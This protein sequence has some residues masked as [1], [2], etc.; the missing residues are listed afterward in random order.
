M[1]VVIRN[2]PEQST[3]KQVEVFFRDKLEKLGIATFHCHKSKGRMAYLTFADNIKALQFMYNHGQTIDGAKGH[4][5][6][7]MKL[8]FMGR[9]INCLQ[10]KNVPDPWLLKSLQK[11][12]SD[13]YLKNQSQALKIIPGK[14]DKPNIEKMDLRAFDV[15]QLFCGQWTYQG[16]T[17]VFAAYYEERRSGRMIFGD[18]ILRVDLRS[19]DNNSPE[20]QIEIPYSSVHS[21][22]IGDNADPSLTLSLS[23]APKLYEMIPEEEP[24]PSQMDP[25]ARML[26]NLSV[27][28]NTPTFKRKRIS[29][30]SQAHETAVSSCFCYR[31]KLLYGRDIFGISKLNRFTNIPSSIKWSTSIEMQTSFG[32]QLSEL[33]TGA[34][35]KKVPF[36]IKFQVQKLAQNGILPPSNTIQILHFVATQLD[37]GTDAASIAT[38]IRNLG[39]AIP[40]AEPQTDA[41]SLAFETL[42]EQLIRMEGSALWGE[43]Y[44]ANVTSHDHIGSI[45][46][47][48]ITPTGVILKGPEP[49]IKNRVLRK[50]S[51]FMDYFL[52]V[53]F[54]DEDGELLR[55]DRRTQ[56]EEIYKGRFKSVFD[57]GVMIAGRKY[58]VEAPAIVT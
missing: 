12:E 53:S 10:S 51:D 39:Y 26:C 17:L 8:F 31:F 35:Y 37:E 49:E 32:A 20:H 28:L 11:E 23:E 13:R 46:K 55:M 34:R 19:R 41:S 1:E 22:T 7:R 3:E 54:T 57:R 2:L 43:I 27:K 6:V 9:P 29:R 24:E 58:E 45:H 5:T 33:L 48:S 16:D 42:K 52:S 47:A 25:L 15:C 40:Y 50:Y 14:F 38:G 44:S 36:E 56:G 4:R 18:R 30:L 21:F